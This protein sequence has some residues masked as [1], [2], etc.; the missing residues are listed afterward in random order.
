MTILTKRPRVYPE[1][2]ASTATL[3]KTTFT[4]PK[5]SNKKFD[6]T[7][8]KEYQI[9]SNHLFFMILTENAFSVF[10]IKETP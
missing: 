10:F 7:H 6:F 3:Q 2:Q 1:Q 8:T 4:P 9:K 5:D